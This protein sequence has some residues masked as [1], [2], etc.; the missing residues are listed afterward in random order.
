MR[1][2]LLGLRTLVVMTILVTAGVLTASAAG[3]T[4]S[5]PVLA[6]AATSPFEDCTADGGQEGAFSPNSE[7]E[8][9]VE[10]NPADPDNIVASWQQDR[11]NN[12]G[13]RGLVAG[14]SADGGAS[15][16]Q[17]AVRGVSTCS[18]H[19]FYNRASDPWHSFSPNGSLYLM[20]LSTSTGI[21][22]A[23]FPDSGMLVSKSEDGGFT[24][25]NP[26][27]LIADNGPNILNDKNSLTADPNDSNFAYAVWDRLVVG[28]E[29][30][31]PI[32]VFQHAVGY[33]GP[34]WFAR[35]TDGG[36]SWEPA[37]MIF[38]PGGVNQTLGNL[39]TVLPPSQGGD[40][41]DFFNL[42]YNFKNAK[43]V[44]GYN[45][46][47]IRSTD[48]GE[49]W[50]GANIVDKFFRAPVRDPET[51]APVRTGDINPDVAV[52]PNNGNIYLAWQD[53]RFANKADIAFTMSTDGGTSWSPT[54]KVNGNSGSAQAFTTSVHVAADGT[55][56][57]SFYDFRNDE[58]DDGELSTDL[59]LIHCHGDCA[60]PGSWMDET[61]V[62][63]KSF[64]MRAAPPAGG[65]FI[66]DYIGL[67]SRGNEFAS[68][69]ITSPGDAPSA[70]AFFS[71]IGP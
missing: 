52:D 61:R 60:D 40:L 16:T 71:L 47:Y 46:A 33:R 14:I 65:F 20:S 7:V 57:I 32:Q 55:V 43:G 39:I 63:P 1:K 62:T 9:W 21:T 68:L 64:D 34:T 67:S 50:S 56:G 45:V 23:G 42:I 36:D 51:G 12:G 31:R 18:G 29:A 5:P 8:P 27:T 70:D 58:L 22:A 19:P 4:A 37:R 30:A 15:W 17:V 3:Y 6:S 11:W 49:T 2:K 13:S 59:W 48:K 54:I 41:L 25:S 44:R 28:A 10:V 35:T 69:F 26:I 24:W 66:G 38:D 53:Q